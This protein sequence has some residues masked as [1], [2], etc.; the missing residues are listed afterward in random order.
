MTDYQQTAEVIDA[1]ILEQV[2]ETVHGLIGRQSDTR[3]G[4]DNHILRARVTELEYQLA[5]LRELILQVE[6]DPTPFLK[7]LDEPSKADFTGL[8]LSLR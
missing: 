7:I 2:M 8:L 3:T 4:V 1:Y 6:D 5:R